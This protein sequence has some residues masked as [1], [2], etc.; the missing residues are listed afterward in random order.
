MDLM[1]LRLL[2]PTANKSQIGLDVVNVRVPLSTPAELRM[3]RESTPPTTQ[4]GFDH[5]PSLR[6]TPAAKPKVLIGPE[7]VET[8]VRV[9]PRDLQEERGAIR[10]V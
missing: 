5:I 1:A 10:L 9:W 8:C 4:M 7:H 6:D 3:P 2:K